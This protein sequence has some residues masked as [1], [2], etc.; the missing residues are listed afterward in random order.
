MKRRGVESGAATLAT[1]HSP[2]FTLQ[3]QPVGFDGIE[4]EAGGGVVDVEADD[5]AVGTEVDVEVSGD[6]AGFGAG[7]VAELDV[8]AVGLGEVAQLHGSPPEST[9]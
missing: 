9:H 5:A 2:L 4:V 8:E 3:R 1:R 7:R 6:L